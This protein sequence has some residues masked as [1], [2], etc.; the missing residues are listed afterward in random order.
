VHE[1]TIDEPV[2]GRGVEAEQARRG[3]HD[4]IAPTEHLVRSKPTIGRQELGGEPLEVVVVQL[5][6][7]APMRRCW[8]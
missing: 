6:N 5:A 2:N 3:R 7:D 8:L 4:H 1:D